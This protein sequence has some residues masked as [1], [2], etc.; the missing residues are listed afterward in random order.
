MLRRLDTAA[1][2]VGLDFSQAQL[3]LATENVPDLP[4]VQADITTLPIA[5]DVFDAIT[6]YH[7]LIHLPR[8]DHQT[9]I[10]ELARVLR[11][12]GRLLVSEGPTEWRGA[13]SDWLDTGFEMRWS[14]ADEQATR[15]ELQSA[16]FTIVD[17]CEVNDDEHWVFLAAQLD[18]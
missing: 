7:T 14:I 12:G 13:N 11:P 9:A 17:D 2:A 16:G 15:T 3:R 8:D 18:G 10:T 4:L 1:I 5:D 6:A